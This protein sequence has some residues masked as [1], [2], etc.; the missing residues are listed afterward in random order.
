MI[1][2]EISAL[3]MLQRCVFFRMG[4]TTINN[5]GLAHTYSGCSFSVKALYTGYSKVTI[6]VALILALVTAVQAWLLT[7]GQR[8]FQ[9][10]TK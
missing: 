10:I 7:H 2:I 3:M 4:I 5:L 6:G 9:S 8:E 1:A